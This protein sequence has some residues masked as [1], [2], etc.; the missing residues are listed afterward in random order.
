MGFK[1]ADGGTIDQAVSVSGS[2]YI[3]IGQGSATRVATIQQFADELDFFTSADLSEFITSAE[4]AGDYLTKVSAVNFITSAST[5]TLINSFGYITSASVSSFIASFNYVS[6]NAVSA[7]YLTK[8]SSSAFTKVAEVCTL[9]ETYNYLTSALAST[10]YIKSPISAT[11]TVTREIRDVSAFDILFGS[12]PTTLYC[13]AIGSCTADSQVIFAGFRSDVIWRGSKANVGFGHPIAGLFRLDNEGTSI[14]AQ[15]FGIEARVDFSGTGGYDKVEL[16]KPAIQASADASAGAS[17][18]RIMGEPDMTD[19]SSFNVE[20]MDYR[21]KQIDMKFRGRIIDNFSNHE[22]S[23]NTHPG[24]ATNRYYY[25]TNYATASVSGNISRTVLIATPPITFAARTTVTRMGAHIL[26]TA[27]G[28][29]AR[30]GF[31]SMQNGVPTSL[32][33]DFG[34]ASAG[35]SGDIEAVG[36]AVMEAGTYFPCIQFNGGAANP[37][38]RCVAMKDSYLVEN[39]GGGVS[40]PVL[41]EA[42]IEDWIY[43][44]N[45]ASLPSAFGGVTRLRVGIVPQ[46]WYRRV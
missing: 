21:S 2:D 13:K 28:V 46:V 11:T 20:F 33:K 14:V 6:A 22:Y 32:L 7:S 4:A 1:R 27:S 34:S 15:G 29:S 5:S 42:A 30:F 39:Y 24:V 9:I 41:A 8:A 17:I 23:P 19:A 16:F 45:T 40:N 43:V 38:V 36:C 35:V 18:I 44:V 26:T 37:G 12:V 3:L 10:T 25:N 31:Y